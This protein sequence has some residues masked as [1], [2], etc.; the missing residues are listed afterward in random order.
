M[1]L[2]SSGLDI[3]E[4]LVTAGHEVERIR[5]SGGSGPKWRGV[6]CSCGWSYHSNGISR[7]DSNA[8]AKRHLREVKSGVYVPV[9]P[10]KFPEGEE[11]ERMRRENDRAIARALWTVE[12]ERAATIAFILARGVNLSPEGLAS[13]IEQGLHLPPELRP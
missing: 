8:E 3:P 5:N 6:R 1:R 12:Q 11:L 13:R 9:E 7:R 10:R 2:G 4:D